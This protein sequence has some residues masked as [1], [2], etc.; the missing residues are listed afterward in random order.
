MKTVLRP[1]RVVLANSERRKKVSTYRIARHKVLGGGKVMLYLVGYG[2]VI[3]AATI[4]AL[5]IGQG[6]ITIAH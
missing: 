3:M 1:E 2:P 5:A 4:A 6:Y